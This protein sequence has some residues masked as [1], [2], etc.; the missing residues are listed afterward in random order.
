[1]TP[2]A[3]TSRTRTREAVSSSCETP[4]R[5]NNTRC[6]PAAHQVHTCFPHAGHASAI[7]YGRSASRILLRIPGCTCPIRRHES[8]QHPSLRMCCTYPAVQSSLV[9]GLRICEGPMPSLAPLAE[10]HVGRRADTGQRSVLLSGRPLRPA[11]TFG[12]QHRKRRV[13]ALKR[14]AA[15]GPLGSPG[16]ALLPHRHDAT[17]GS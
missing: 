17:A 13:G 6:W 4:D 7:V 3:H 11:Y 12:T 2:V 5:C 9:V 14:S 8:G 15:S 16:C 1:M 10:P